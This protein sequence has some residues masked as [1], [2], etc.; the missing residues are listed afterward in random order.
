MNIG[1]LTSKPLSLFF[2]NNTQCLKPCNWEY[3]LNLSKKT[4]ADVCIGKALG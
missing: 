2:L 4:E 1:E 3:H